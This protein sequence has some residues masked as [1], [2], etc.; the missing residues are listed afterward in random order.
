MTC[1][2]WSGE[3]EEGSEDRWKDTA[4]SAKSS[5][6]LSVQIFIPIL[7]SSPPFLSQL[8]L[9]LSLPHSSIHS[10]CIHPSIIYS[11]IIC[12]S[13]IL[14]RVTLKTMVNR[15]AHH[16]ST[17]IFFSFASL[18]RCVCMSY[19]TCVQAWLYWLQSV[20]VSVLYGAVVVAAEPWEKELEPWE[21]TGATEVPYIPEPGCPP[22]ALLP[23]D[24]EQ[25][26]REQ[27]RRH[28][29]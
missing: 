22:W 1:S 21:A 29:E 16:A 3:R 11:A 18:N 17:N 8:Q 12:L 23:T 27:Q 28:N 5:L 19:S 13:H 4:L 25:Q 10:L 14:G 6:I 24:P 2:E 9:T 7:I 15:Q 20:E 26:R